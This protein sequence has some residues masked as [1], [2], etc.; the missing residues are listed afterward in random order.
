M[1]SDGASQGPVGAAAGGP[2]LEF[3]T[4]VIRDD[5]LLDGAARLLSQL[6][7]TTL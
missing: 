4:F 2:L 7:F 5:R 1:I 3:F 6:M